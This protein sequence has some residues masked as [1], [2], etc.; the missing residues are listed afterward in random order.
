MDDLSSA[1]GELKRELKSRHLGMISLGGAIGTGL[2]LASG[3]TI[4]EAG[5]GGA[6]LA[7]TLIGVMV[8]FLMTS[9]GEMA[10]FMP[11]SGSF[12]TY[13]TKFVEPSL[14]FATGW[15]YWYNWSITL[16][17][18]L[19]AASQIMKYWFPDVPGMIF[20]AIFLIIIVI[21][22]IISVKG[23]GETEF[24]LASIK[25][26]IVLLFI[27]VGILMILGVFTNGTGS[28][29]L[30]NW[31]TGDAPFH[32]GITGIISVFMIAG[33]AFQG[34][35][36]LGV[37][38]GESV[39]PKKD[40]PKAIKSVF[41]RIIIFYIATIFIIGTLIPYF[42]PG[43]LDESILVS[44]FT[45]VFAGLGIPNADSFMN[46]IILTAVLSA[47]NSGAYVSTR[48]LNAL[49]KQG[50]APKIFAK[51]N[52]RGIPVPALILTVAVGSL[53]LLSSLFGEGEVYNWL[54]NLSALAGFMT[55]LF[56]ALS[57][58]RFRRGY[59][60]QGLDLNNLS[61]KAKLFPFGPLLALFACIFVILGQNYQAFF[62][63]DINWGSLAASYMGIP[64]FLIVWLIH[65]LIH[66]SHI[67]KYKDMEF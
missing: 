57:H 46:A 28:V 66:K 27:I 40:I 19:S 53:A 45:Q 62:T 37:A 55:W 63:G 6:L 59:V 13:T 17:F 50:D 49:A 52:K 64:L 41:W 21:I 67:V 44:P 29:G 4:A 7:Y 65:K 3:Q 31:T 9:L 34:T 8:Y 42:A 26:F 22:N 43:L 58:F 20:S 51:I 25:V 2:F 15:N 35:E 30:G 56:I 33:F 47:G 11:T 39:N 12:S 61:Y 24:W 38:A 36:N 48:M 16:A 5:P 32:N 14:G 1:N 60:K 10:S 18:E 23:F 54:L